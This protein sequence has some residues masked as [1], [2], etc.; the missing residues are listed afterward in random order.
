MIREHLD[1]SRSDV[2]QTGSIQAN[3]EVS[4]PANGA[5]NKFMI[6]FC[7]LKSPCHKERVTDEKNRETHGAREECGHTGEERRTQI[8]MQSGAVGR[9]GRRGRGS[10]GGCWRR[11]TRAKT[12]PKGHATADA[13]SHEG[14]SMRQQGD[15]TVVGEDVQSVKKKKKV[16][17][18][19]GRLTSGTPRRRGTSPGGAQSV[20]MACARAARARRAVS[21][22]VALARAS[23]RLWHAAGR[24]SRRR[25]S[26]GGWR[27][28]CKTQRRVRAHRVA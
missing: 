8:G 20:C 12:T 6:C 27:G 15:K 21:G 10:S 14:C 7:L 4:R 9:T 13:S 25:G 2:S 24:P 26:A 5:G 19:A 17:H 16:P 3:G 1:A 11:T 18:G 22:V 28:E 23:V